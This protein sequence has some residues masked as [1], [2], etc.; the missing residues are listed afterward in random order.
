MGAMLTWLVGVHTRDWW[1]HE[2]MGATQRISKGSEVRA[3]KRAIERQR[4]ANAKRLTIASPA[5]PCSPPR[6]QLCN[7]TQLYVAAPQPATATPPLTLPSACRCRKCP[8]TAFLTLGTSVHIAKHHGHAQRQ[9]RPAAD[10]PIGSTERG[11]GPAAHRQGLGSCCTPLLHAAAHTSPPFPLC[12]A[13]QVASSS[14][15]RRL[16]TNLM[17]HTACLPARA[18]RTTCSTPR[19]LSK[20]SK[21]A[22]MCRSPSAVV[23]KTSPA[24]W[25][26]TAC[27]RRRSRCR[28]WPWQ[29]PVHRP[30]SAMHGHR[31]W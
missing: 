19:A 24:R 17:S 10:S 4:L 31:V 18:S 12:A 30:A 26:S 25:L 29:T 2:Y 11:N 9:S 22:A 13:P 1:A 3:V 15:V 16:A 21:P 20:G 8:P 23:P 28:T 5:D 27:S 6:F 14:S 7:Q